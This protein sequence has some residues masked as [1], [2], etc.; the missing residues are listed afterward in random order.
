LLLHNGR[1]LSSAFAA[2]MTTCVVTDACHLS[3]E[4]VNLSDDDSWAAAALAFLL[5]TG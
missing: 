3:M 2:R 4:T 1:Q 5:S